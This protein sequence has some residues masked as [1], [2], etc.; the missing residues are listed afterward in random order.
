MI[1]VQK[2]LLYILFILLPT[3]LG[4]HFWPSWSQVFGIKVDYLSPTIYLTDLIIIGLL[5]ISKT[6]KTPQPVWILIGGLNIIYSLSPLLTF[7]SWVRVFEFYLLIHFLITNKELLISSIKKT[8]PISLILI[9]LIAC[10][11]FLHQSSLGGIF[12]YL[13]ERPLS[14]TNPAVAKVQLLNI[15]QLIRPYSTFSHPN[16]L[17]GYLLV[18]FLLVV[19]LKPKKWFG[20]L[21]SKLAFFSVILSALT[22]AITF[23]KMN[24]YLL[25]TYLVFNLASKLPTKAKSLKYL[26]VTLA[27][28]FVGLAVL[29][30]N[31]SSPSYTDRV[32]LIGKATKIIETHPLTGLGLGAF[33]L[34][35]DQVLTSHTLNL[36][37][38]PVHNLPLLLASE[39]GVPTLALL[40][41]KLSSCLVI[42]GRPN[43]FGI[44]AAVIFITGLVDHYWI[45][46][47]QNQLLLS[48]VIALYIIKQNHESSFS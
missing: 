28:F 14:Y 8:L 12:Y 23:S 42:W 3:Q 30:T 19:F 22:I 11:Q 9:S 45:T 26:I 21:Q 46:L 2:F 5:L 39:L 7:L 38:Q 20:S 47:H 33:P 25:F 34:S 44:I 37:F 6:F 29:I 27:L 17:S 13:G 1:R 41:L 10:I 35:Q 16:S 32:Q 48:V 15:S 43:S 31:L 36:N 4:I 40:L 24:I 18:G